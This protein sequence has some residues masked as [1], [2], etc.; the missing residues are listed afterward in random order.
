MRKHS[1]PKEITVVWWF[2]GSES[3]LYC[4]QQYVYEAECRC[5]ICDVAVC[6][7]CIA[8]IESGEHLCP[9]CLAEQEQ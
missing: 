2:D 3:C 8:M 4:H 9:N 5:M 7:E 6:P 1:S